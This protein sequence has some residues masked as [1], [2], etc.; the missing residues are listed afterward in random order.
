MNKSDFVAIF[1]RTCQHIEA[2]YLDRAFIESHWPLLKSQYGQALELCEEKS[3]FD[4]LMSKLL[5]QELPLSHCA[6][7]TPEKAK[8][9]DALDKGLEVPKMLHFSSKSSKDWLYLRMPSFTIPRFSFAK[10]LEALRTAKP[11]QTAI[12][13]VRLNDGG[14]MSA[15]A[16][17]MGCF[18]QGE[19]VVCHS[20][21]QNWQEMANPLVVYP[22]QES[23]NQGNEADVKLAAAYP[24]VEWRTAHVPPVYLDNT[25]VVLSGERCYSCGELFCKAVQD[26]GRGWVLGQ[27][28]AGCVVGA[29]DD[30]ECG[31]GYRLMLPFVTMIA[32]AGEE[33]EG[34]GVTPQIPWQFQ[35]PDSEELTDEEI[36]AVVNAL[37]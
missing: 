20:R 29:R 8:E 11:K 31:H 22:Q 3:A 28:T 2:S 21:L 9:V 5:E 6:F 32:P 35:T 18:I 37:R 23:T 4:E 1:C 12:I 34:R 26:Y 19:R 36:E 25:L 7:I 15:V 33:V 17:V 10:V 14:S 24:H 27:K 13:D 30:Y 16:E